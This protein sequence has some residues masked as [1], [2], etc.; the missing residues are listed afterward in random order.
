MKKFDVVIVGSGAGLMVVEAALQSGKAC[1]LI[2]QAK[3]GG[4]CLTKGCIPS[5]MLVYPAD[6]IREAEKARR[7]GLGFDSP[8]VDW[9]QISARLWKQIDFSKEL[10]KNFKQLDGLTV[11]NGVA[12]FTGKKSLQVRSP[13]GNYSEEFEG[14]IIVL[15]AGARSFV[16][17]IQNLEQT[18]Y[19]TSESFFGEKYPKKPWDSLL[20]LGGGAIGTEF[21]HIFSAFG[22]KV[23]LIDRN[24]RIIKTEEEEISA[25]VEAELK[26]NGVDILTCCD[27]V[28]SGKSGNKKYLTLENNRTR[29]RQ[30]TEADE[31][32]LASGVR[33]NGDSL[34]LERTGIETDANGWIKTDAFLET[35]QKDVYAI[36]DM[37]GLFQ[38]RHKANYEAEILTNN[39]FGSGV[40][41]MAY[42]TA[43]P[44]AIFTCPQVAHL[45]MTEA[46]AKAAGKRYWVGKN[47][48]S[49]IAGGIA[50]GISDHSPDN[51]FVKIILGEESTILGVHI[52]GP[53]AS[54][55]VQPFVYLMNANHRCQIH[56]MKKGGT[57]I[58]PPVGSYAP[59]HDSMV[60]HPSFNELTAWALNNVDWS[61]RG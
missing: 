24:P 43:V 13:G 30:V 4:T 52:A 10:E 33:S 14:E 45:G 41:K 48:Y 9:E 21:A 5:K 11:Y 27:V 18:G 29:E 15:A 16:P 50:M 22:T 37:N 36:G 39:L 58:C 31:I 12:E 23:T 46:Q 44:W 56:D 7:I 49:Q 42:Y 28:S 3:F 57:L 60:I 8:R 54:M 61:E 2:E 32:L 55:L 53:H 59:I 25:F 51:G 40:K 26:A 20:I 17:P 34:H 35:S 6:V 47:Y 19:L 1:A 38:F